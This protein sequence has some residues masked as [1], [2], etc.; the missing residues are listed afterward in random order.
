MWGRAAAGALHVCGVFVT[1][2]TPLRCAAARLAW[3]VRSACMQSRFKLRS[4]GDSVILGDQVVLVSSKD[5]NTQ[6]HVSAVPTA[7][8]DREI[9]GS[10]VRSAFKA[11]TGVLRETCV[12]DTASAP[13]CV[14]GT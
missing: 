12:L 13:C 5:S 3:R 1:D 8:G 10:A 7:A 14:F 6:L 4:E 2:P 9:N 11:R